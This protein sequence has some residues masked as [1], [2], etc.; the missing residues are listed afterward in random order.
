MMHTEF[1]T[2]QAE[3]LVEHYEA[4]FSPILKEVLPD[5]NAPRIHRTP[6][7]AQIIAFWEEVRREKESGTLGTPF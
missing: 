1:Q 2:H 7:R 5:P 3:K 4:T 6:T